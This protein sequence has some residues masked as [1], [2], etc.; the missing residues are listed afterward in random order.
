MVLECKREEKV[1]L[2]L[3]IEKNPDI[4]CDDGDIRIIIEKLL[5]VQSMKMVKRAAEVT[6]LN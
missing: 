1:N 3:S 5:D 2:F 6:L 4:I